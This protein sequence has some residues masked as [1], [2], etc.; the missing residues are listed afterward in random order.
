MEKTI[1]REDDGELVIELRVAVS[2]NFLEF[3]NQVQDKLTEA[4]QRER[5]FIRMGNKVADVGNA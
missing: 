2:T 1:I 4:N 5:G 3:E